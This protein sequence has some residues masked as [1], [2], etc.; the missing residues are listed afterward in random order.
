MERG[1]LDLTEKKQTEAYFKNRRGYDTRSAAA[2]PSRAGV[3]HDGVGLGSRDYTNGWWRNS[4]RFHGTDVV[5]CKIVYKVSAVEPWGGVEE[6]NDDVL[7]VV[8]VLGL[9]VLTNQI[10]LDEEDTLGYSVGSFD[11]L[12]Y[13]KN[14]WLHFQKTFLRKRR[15]WI[16]W[17]QDVVHEAEM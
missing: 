12:T 16:W 3:S 5:R 11:G 1:G 2:L 6:V 14:L 15:M 17:D 13:G 7:M 8:L 4:T 10:G 9:E